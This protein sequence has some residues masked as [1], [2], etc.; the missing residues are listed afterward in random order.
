MEFDTPYNNQNQEND[1]KL[2]EDP[3]QFAAFF[4]QLNQAADTSFNEVKKGL[5]HTIMFELSQDS[6][7]A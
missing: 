2:F 5:F 1:P 3:A 4:D 6:D 7:N